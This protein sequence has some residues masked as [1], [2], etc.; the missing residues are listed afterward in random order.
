MW[1]ERLTGFREESPKQVRENISVEGE[2]LKSNINGKSYK[3][4]T[5]EIPTLGDLRQCV[6][7]VGSR[8]GKI[9]VGEVV[10]DSQRDTFDVAVDRQGRVYVLD[11][12]NNIIRVFEKKVS[13]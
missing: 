4:G 10:A 3:Y 9:S 8:P 12:I 5:L 7:S 1:F 13:L 2:Y 6:D 11:T